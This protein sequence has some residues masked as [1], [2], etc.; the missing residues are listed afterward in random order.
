[1]NG[2]NPKAVLISKEVKKEIMA[3]D[4]FVGVIEKSSKKN[5][6]EKDL[7]LSFEMFREFGS[8]FSRFIENNELWKFNLSH[9][10]VKVSDDLYEMLDLSMRYHK[11]TNGIFDISVPPHLLKEGYVKSS[12]EG[13]LG[14]TTVTDKKYEN[15][16][17]L[18][19]LKD[20]H[21]KKP[22]N[23]TVDLGGIGK[24]FII[25]K[26]AKSLSAKYENF[27]IDA[28]GDIY[29]RGKDVAN[30]N[31][32]WALDVEN[33]IDRKSS[34]DIIMLNNM[35]V[36]TSG[37][38]RRNWVLDKMKKNHLI[39]PGTKKSVSNNLI[40]VTTISS[41][42]IEAD[43]MA[44]TLLIMGLEQGLQYSENNNIASLFI[45][46]SKEIVRSSI[47]EGYVWKP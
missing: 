3:T 12:T 29:C 15:L 34:V 17:S 26:V 31:Q 38:N 23:L 8:N 42:I 19:L 45:K 4:I 43:I 30:H 1:M 18:D 2:N 27:I 14:A 40:S 46:D 9:G 10:N 47:M 24:G 32:Y 13:Y 20:K 16:S 36:A 35:A 44:K 21:V 37:I 39:D 6:A 41:S 5:L 25:E 22:K 11:K 7:D 28:G 33:P